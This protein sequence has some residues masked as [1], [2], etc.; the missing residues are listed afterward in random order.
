MMRAIERLN[1]RPYVSHVF[2]TIV[3][4]QM[5]ESLIS[6]ACIH[7]WTQEET[8]NEP[9]FVVARSAWREA[10]HKRWTKETSLPPTLRWQHSSR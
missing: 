1:R 5:A 6:P 4:M 9:A 3:S 10:L 2:P 8:G 7:A